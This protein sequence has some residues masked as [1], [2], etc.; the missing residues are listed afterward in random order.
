MQP[1]QLSLPSMADTETDYTRE[2]RF[3]VVLY[4]GVSL[5]IYIN[6]VANELFEMACATPRHGHTLDDT[7]ASGTR[8]VYRRLSWLAANTALRDRYAAALQAELIEAKRE[9]RSQR[10]VWPEKDLGGERAR[11]IVDVISGT[12]AGGINGVF[13]AKA[14]ACGE[15]FDTLQN[16]WIQ[17]GDFGKLINDADSYEG[18]PVRLKL[19]RGEPKSLLNSDRMYLK[20]LQAMSEMKPLERA[21]P[22][23]GTTTH[24]PL[25]EQLDLFVTAT[26]IE[27]TAVPLRLFDKVVTERRHK[28]FFQFRHPAPPEET[29]A[30]QQGDFH[31]DNVPFL[32]FVARCT[33]S[34]PFA[35]EPMTLAAIRRLSGIKSLGVWDRFFPNLPPSEV[36][37]GQH[38]H[39]A[40][41]DGGYLDNKPFS[42]VVEALAQRGG[43]LP[44]ERKL[45]YIEPAPERLGPSQIPT[46]EAQP[47][48]VTN[49]VAALTSIPL[50]ETIREDLQVVL[51]R[52]RRIERVERMVQLGEL[53]VEQALQQNAD[54]F[55]SVARADGVVAP[56]QSLKLSQLVKYYGV[57]FLPYRRLRVYAL[58]DT[59]AARIAVRWGV[60]PS[61]DYCYALRVLVRLWRER[62]FHEEGA[63]GRETVN[64]FLDQF[65]LPY[66]MRRQALLLRKIDQYVRLLRRYLAAASV[67]HDLLGESNRPELEEFLKSA[68][69]RAL[70]PDVSTPDQFALQSVLNSS[71]WLQ[72]ALRALRVLKLHLLR[73]QE[74]LQRIDQ[75]QSRTAVDTDELDP[76][77]RAELREVLRHLLG[78]RD[79]EEAP[80]ALSLHNGGTW[81]LKGESRS[82]SGSTLQERVLARATELFEQDST[83]VGALPQTCVQR[84]LYSSLEALRFK[85]G[86]KLGNKED[87]TPANVA[88]GRVW[89]LLGR[90]VLK[91]QAGPPVRVALQLEAPEISEVAGI[92][93]TD[94]IE[95]LRSEAGTT[96]RWLLAHYFLQFDS[97]DQTSFQLYYDTGIGEPATVEVVRVSPMDATRLVD[98]AARDKGK[99]AGTSLANFGAFLDERWRR[100]DILWGR[101]DGAERLIQTVLPGD[102]SRSKL[103]REALID[104]A[105]DAILREALIPHGR[106]ELVAV[107]IEA[108][109]A[110]DQDTSKRGKSESTLDLGE[111]LRN[112]LVQLRVGP[113]VQRDRLQELLA[114]LLDPSDLRRHVQQARLNDH[115][116][117]PKA[118]LRNASRAVAVTGR[119]LQGVSRR[120]A[121]LPG[122]SRWLARAGLVLQSTV[123][124]SMPGSLAQG[125]FSYAVKVLYGLI[126]ILLIAS[127]AFGSREMTSVVLKTLGVI[128]GLHLLLALLGDV[129]REV[130]SVR[131]VLSG[132][133]LVG[134]ATLA[135]LGAS[136]LY[137]LGPI[138]LLCGNVASDSA[139]AD[140][141]SWPCRA[142]ISAPR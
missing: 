42:Y 44:I 64:A 101:L 25:V 136:G 56:W 76:V 139:A 6:G 30:K 22:H 60:D 48:A 51:K 19:Q 135:L 70:S 113:S 132:A 86:S 68:L 122:L 43:M 142:S 105:H 100:N 117:D 54:P 16:L 94:E 109:Q 26:D 23:P 126:F 2:V 1:L 130:T 35:F 66:R 61:S 111:R 28:Q 34:F 88:A 85:Q 87:R 131:R 27:G 50:Y 89:H 92:V 41:G 95:Q 112:L 138:A 73:A 18:L 125:W 134:A 103:V 107:V 124:L 38:E 123:A 119:V 69:A 99:L 32:A 78:D 55:A 93:T 77:L 40:F 106:K 84:A 72:Q 128:A 11:L 39:R 67:G 137:K 83:E 12:S 114:S 46:P 17:E 110:L 127:F 133:F 108:L 20:L 71:T 14:L 45:L 49:V 65:D 24:S 90:P 120:P 121:L 9:N 4:G 5:A 29:N 97:F 37:A 118:L 80:L 53:E 31:S 79:P 74:D 10:D 21:D 91:T 3:G 141:V 63:G 81:I 8:E 57:G 96:L 116:L 104:Q 15:R 140:H 115:P 102:D 59:L 7:G 62:Q 36:R 52:N 75:E 82:K 13:L 98:E 47:D 129:L 58:C 33:S